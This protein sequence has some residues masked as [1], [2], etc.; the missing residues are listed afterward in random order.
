L[1]CV[2]V[3][4]CVCVCGPGGGG[5]RCCELWH[6][7]ACRAWPRTWPSAPRPLSSGR[8][9]HALRSTPRRALVPPRAGAG[10]RDAPFSSSIWYTQRY[11]VSCPARLTRTRCCSSYLARLY[12]VCAYVCVCVCG[13]TSA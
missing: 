6:W 8:H 3:R 2:S 11:A 13:M 1:T 10:A 12:G 5:G 9:T 7:V 4:V